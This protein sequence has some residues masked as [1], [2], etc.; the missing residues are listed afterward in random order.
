M[1]QYHTVS[2]PYRAQSYRTLI[3]IVSLHARVQTFQMRPIVSGSKYST[4]PSNNRSQRVI[5][6]SIRQLPFSFITI[7]FS[8]SDV[9]CCTVHNHSISDKRP[10]AW[11][12]TSVR[13]SSG[14]TFPATV[15]LRRVST[16]RRRHTASCTTTTARR[17]MHMRR[18]FAAIGPS[19]L[20]RGR[21]GNRVRS[22][23]IVCWRL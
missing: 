19:D 20:G 17:A 22:L 1:C 8:T 2:V 18:A 13:P 21:M 6:S 16:A 7:L 5:I 9:W 14:R 12:V 15:R 11:R 4:T 23:L 10:S 3:P